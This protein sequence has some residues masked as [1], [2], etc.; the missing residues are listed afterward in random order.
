[1]GSA[2]RLLDVGVSIMVEGFAGLEAVEP[3]LIG[4]FGMTVF[5]SELVCV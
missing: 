3:D 1:M 5:L 2:A 4:A